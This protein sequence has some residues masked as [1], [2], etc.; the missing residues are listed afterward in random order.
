MANQSKLT[1]R[2]ASQRGAS[3]ISYST[4]GRYINLATNTVHD[5]LSRLPVQPTAS[6]KAFWL[7]VLALVTADVTALP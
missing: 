2:V 1:I 4:G 7:S 6:E 3:S 5:D